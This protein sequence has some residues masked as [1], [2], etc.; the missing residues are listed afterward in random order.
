[1]RKLEQYI[2]KGGKRLRLGYTTGSCAAAAAA[3]AAAALL[4]GE[5]PAVVRLRTPSGQELELDVEQLEA[6]PESVTCAVQKDAG[7]DPDVTDG[8]LVYAAVSKTEEGFAVRGGEGV[9]RITREGLQCPVGEAAI[10]PVPRAMI[11][12][13]LAEAA[14]QHGYTGG[15]EAVVSI[16]A[17]VALAHRTFNPRLGIT[18]GISI[19]GTSG[20]VEPMSEDALVATIRAEIDTRQAVGQEVLLLTPGNYGRDFAQNAFSISLEEGVKC[21]NYIGEALDYAV[22]R[23]AGKILLIG[24]AGKLVKLAGGIMNTHSSLADARMEILACHGALIGL[25]TEQVRRIFS[26]VTVD[27]ADRLLRE[28]GA[29]RAVWDSVAGRVQFQLEQRV[30]GKAEVAA[31]AF[32]AGGVVMRTDGFHRLLTLMHKE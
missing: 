24:H 3:A 2:V 9:G 11:R 29:D 18:G 19:L 8:I 10:N 23:G 31:C 20:I 12:A 22:Y 28:W 13:A 16:P 27:A 26:C 17:G 21:S 6:R 1:M 4:G 5:N 15:L 14:R 32:C 7:D 30:A 25:S